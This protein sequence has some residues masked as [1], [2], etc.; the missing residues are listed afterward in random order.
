MTITKELLQQKYNIKPTTRIELYCS[1]DS[2]G[3]VDRYRRSRPSVRDEMLLASTVYR[4]PMTDELI[5]EFRKELNITNCDD[6]TTDDVIFLFK[7]LY[8]LPEQTFLLSV[9]KNRLY[10]TKFPYTIAHSCQTNTRIFYIVSN[11]KEYELTEE[12]K[13]EK[14]KIEKQK[15]GNKIFNTIFLPRLKDIFN[16][17]ELEAD[18][19]VNEEYSTICFEKYVKSYDRDE[20]CLREVVENK[21]KETINEKLKSLGISKYDLRIDLSVTATIDKTEILQQ[22][23]NEGE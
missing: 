10:T 17:I 7:K 21:I 11:F 5:D 12:E 23:N 20:S 3:K 18:E 16:E 6:L 22:L 8:N 9:S 4:I 14:E 2:T 15:N 1:F 13:L 19:D